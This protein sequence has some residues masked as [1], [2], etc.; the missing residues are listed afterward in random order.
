[1]MFNT[2]N[3]RETWLFGKVVKKLNISNIHLKRTSNMPEA[4]LK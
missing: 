2:K 4:I 1:M 3:C